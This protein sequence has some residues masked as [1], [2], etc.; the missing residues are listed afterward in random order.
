VID[1]D[2]G[3]MELPG[4]NKVGI[5]ELESLERLALRTES[6]DIGGGGSDK[7]T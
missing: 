6:H 7:E 4:G 3:L 2:I 1:A 5:L